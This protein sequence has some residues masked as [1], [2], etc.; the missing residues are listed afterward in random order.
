[1]KPVSVGLPDDYKADDLIGEDKWICMANCLHLAAK[2]FPG[3]LELILSYFDQVEKKELEEMDHL[4]TKKAKD[5]ALR[6][7]SKNVHKDGLFSPLHVAASN[8]S[9]LSTR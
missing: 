8:P 1:M 4:S 6:R 9:S 3:G 5:F 7:H 2:Y